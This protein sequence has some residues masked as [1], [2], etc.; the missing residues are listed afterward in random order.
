MPALRRLVLSALALAALTFPASAA[1]IVNGHAPTREYPFMAALEWQGSQICG[2]TLV[3][4]EW[5][6]T[7]AHCITEEDGSLTPAKDLT[8]QIGGVEYVGSPIDFYEQNDM[9][10]RIGA[11]QVIRHERYQSPEDSSYDIALVKLA[12]PSKYAPVPLADPATQKARWAP[13]QEGIVIGYGGPFY[14]APSVLGDL[15]QTEV[16]LVDDEEC[17]AAYNDRAFGATGV[18]E[19]TTMV[20]AGNLEG[21][22][23]SCQGD[24]GGPLFVSDGAGGLL[25]AGVVSWGFACGLPNFYGVYAR[26]GD[27]PL[28]TWIQSRITPATTTASKRKASA[29]RRTA[30]KRASA[31]RV[32]AKRRALERR[33]AALR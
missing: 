18:V 28:N 33:T 6:L 8:F 9:G 19:T 32:A 3:A 7:A 26:V 2:S 17:A 24:S 13:G 30:T 5:I 14:Q 12:R 10:E 20:C 27:T 21:T 25:Q 16:P 4:P 23:D 22:E 1:A 31:K 29:K 11:T 15:Q